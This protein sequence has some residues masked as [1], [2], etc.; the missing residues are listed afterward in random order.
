M[1]F[2]EK[3]KLKKKGKIIMKKIFKIVLGAFAVL[4]ILGVIGA[5]ADSGESQVNSSDN[6]VNKQEAEA[7]KETGEEPTEEIEEEADEKAEEQGK[8]TK[9][10]YDQIKQG[11]GLTG[12]GGATKEEV[13]EVLG[14]PDSTTESQVDDMKMETMSWTTWEFTS[15]SVT[16]T[17]GKVSSKMWME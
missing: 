16:L 14:E 17:N 2:L 13:I 12:E 8:I 7:E 11:D 10:K 4:L 9:E 6:P 5:I 3:T 15:I 1:W